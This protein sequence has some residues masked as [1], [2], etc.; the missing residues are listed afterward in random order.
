MV[1]YGL[2]H[3]FE[4]ICGAPKCGVCKE[5]A[6]EHMYSCIQCS[7]T[8]S[9]KAMMVSPCNAPQPTSLARDLTYALV[10]PVL[11]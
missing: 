8:S 6:E 9:E 5:E 3:G 10:L 4:P 11:F 1:R 7:E 2:S